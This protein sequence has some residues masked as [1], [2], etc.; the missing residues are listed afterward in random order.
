M[1]MMMIIIIIIIIDAHLSCAIEVISRGN[2]CVYCILYCCCCRCCCHG[3]RLK[4]ATFDIIVEFSYFVCSMWVF[5][6]RK[7]TS[8]TYIYYIC[9]IYHYGNM[10][11]YRYGVVTAR[12]SK[13]HRHLEF[14]RCC[15]FSNIFVRNWDILFFFLL[16]Y[17]VYTIYY[18]C[19]IYL[20]IYQKMHTCQFARVWR[21][22]E[23]DDNR[24]IRWPIRHRVREREETALL[25]MCIILWW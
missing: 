8:N 15:F 2:H 22:K 20:Y 17:I 14:W 5:Y 19:F 3:F 7:H 10:I 13:A 12:E 11:I 24:I 18:I 23:S 16:E 6:A 9:Y 25:H 21:R 1:T 4:R